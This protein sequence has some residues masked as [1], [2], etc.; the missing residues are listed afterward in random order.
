MRTGG[1]RFDALAMP[2]WLSL[3]GKVYHRRTAEIL[4][5]RRHLQTG[6]EESTQYLDDQEDILATDEGKMNK[7]EELYVN[8]FSEASL[9]LR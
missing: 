9:G 5:H 3:G 6:R 7:Q 1:L 8:V 2:M 4:V